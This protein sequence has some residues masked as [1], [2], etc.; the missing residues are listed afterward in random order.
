MT[1]TEKLLVILAIT[2][3][4]IAF[5]ATRRY[6]QP[7]L[8]RYRRRYFTKKLLMFFAAAVV[9]Y[10]GL[11]FLTDFAG[12]PKTRTVAL[13]AMRDIPSSWTD[14]SRIPASQT[15]GPT[16]YCRASAYAPFLIRVDYGWVSGPLTGDGGSVWY[17]WIFGAVFRAHEFSHWSA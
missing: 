5:F 15:K 6:W 7:L 13:R 3:F 17:L 4:V 9:L 2:I 14:I 10:V 11:W 16:Y 8:L 1:A 12:V